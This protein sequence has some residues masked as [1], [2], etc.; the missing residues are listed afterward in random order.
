MVDGATYRAGLAGWLPTDD[1]RAHVG[2]LM[3]P[4]LE[5]GRMA[6]WIAPPSQGING[7]SVDYSY[8]RL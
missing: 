2:S 8:V 1:D 6:G 4:C 7:K 3:Q 5:P